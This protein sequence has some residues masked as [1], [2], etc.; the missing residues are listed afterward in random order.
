VKN[1]VTWHGASLIDEID[2]ALDAGPRLCIALSYVRVGV[3][4]L[5]PDTR[6]NEFF[7]PKRNKLRDH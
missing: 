3:E 1:L 6:L 2:R 4:T 7:D 5:T